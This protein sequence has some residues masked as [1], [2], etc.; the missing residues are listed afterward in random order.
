MQTGHMQTSSSC[1]DNSPVTKQN[2]WVWAKNSNREDGQYFYQNCD[3]CGSV[4]QALTGDYS[5]N[6]YI[7]TAPYVTLHMTNGI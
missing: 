3:Y 2:G 1:I 4:Y 6:N 5:A 7:Y